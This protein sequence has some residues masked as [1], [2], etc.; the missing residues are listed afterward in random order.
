MPILNKE[1]Y[2]GEEDEKIGNEV[3]FVSA[4][5][6]STHASLYHLTANTYCNVWMR[7][8]QCR[9]PDNNRFLKAKLGLAVVFRHQVNDTTVVKPSANQVMDISVFF[10]VVSQCTF[11][12]VQGIFKLIALQNQCMLEKRKQQPYRRILSWHETHT[13]MVQCLQMNLFQ[14]EFGI[15]NRFPVKVHRNRLLLPCYQCGGRE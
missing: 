2:L 11:K 14:M 15:N 4:V 5:G 6:Q 9:G 13:K 12:Q 1:A 8:S 7:I 3:R 10:F